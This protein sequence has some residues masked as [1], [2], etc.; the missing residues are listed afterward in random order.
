MA[1]D[2]PQVNFKDYQYSVGIGAY[3]VNYVETHNDE[4]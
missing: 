3:G 2:T 4:T 1:D